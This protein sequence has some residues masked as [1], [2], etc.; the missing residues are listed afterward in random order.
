[1][2]QKIR[3]VRQPVLASAVLAACLALGAAF[4]ANAADVKSGLKIAFVPKQINNPYEVIA[5]DGGMA[6]LPP[7][8]RVPRVRHYAARFFS[9]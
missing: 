5:D 4:S 3:S 8:F 7:V 1:M 9:C 6:E 2:L